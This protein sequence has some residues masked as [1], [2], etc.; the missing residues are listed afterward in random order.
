MGRFT[1]RVVVPF[2]LLAIP[3][4]ILAALGYV[5]AARQLGRTRDDAIARTVNAVT[6]L[7]ADYQEALRRETLLLARD[8]AVV[9]GVARGDWATLARGASPRVLA[10]TQDGLADFVVIRDERGAPLVQVPAGPPPS[11]P[12]A[13]PSSEPIAALRLAGGRP[14]FLIVAPING[15]TERAPFGATGTVSAGR[16]LE[17]LGPSLD[18]LP[19]HP[20]VLFLAGDRAL[21]ASRG[22]LPPAGWTAATGSGIATVA[23]Q[24]WAL[25]RLAGET[26]ESP[27]GSLWV[28]LPVQE[29]AA[30]ER[31]LGHEFLALLAAG[32]VVLGGVVLAFLPSSSRSRPTAAGPRMENPRVVLER[33][34]RELEALNAIATT[35]G[36]GANLETTARETLEVVRGLA[37]MDVG[38]VYQLDASGRELI[39]VAGSGFDPRYVETSRVRPVEGSRIGDAV[40]SNQILVTHLDA[41]PP[42]EEGLRQMAAER[43]H[44]TQLAMPIPVEEQTWGVMALVSQETREFSGE[45]MRILSSVAQ[46]VGLAVERARLRDMAAARLSRLEAQRVIERHISEQLDT[47]E[48]LV[49][50]ARSA[51]RLVGGG[52]AALYMLEGDLLRPRAWSDIGDWIRDLRFNVG[53]GVAGAAMESGRGLMVNDYPSSPH[54]MA[55]FVPFTSRLLAG[56][57]MAGG[58]TLG[59]MTAGRAPGAAPFTDEDLSTLADFA[60]Q[61]AVAL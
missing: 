61:A 48:L 18:R 13:P 56:P 38:S 21:G 39:M 11:L 6:V 32:A 27:D 34:N 40:R 46:Q 8:P 25:R 57:L 1:R 47:E 26:L 17:G 24:P 20:A 5:S 35:I 23:G 3:L 19:A 9:E 49:V 52:Y 43:A 15:A 2:L 7:V 4:G 12:G 22:D 53:T 14:Y 37:G 10:I 28:A 58:R 16:R 54:A 44:R 42:S 30:A 41:V 50:I 59:V 60:T 31:R 29:F 45:E 33:R 55:E 51:Q 36:R